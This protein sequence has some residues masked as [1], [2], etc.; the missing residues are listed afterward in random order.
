VRRHPRVRGKQQPE[1]LECPRDADTGPGRVTQTPGPAPGQA[2]KPPLRGWRLIV[3]AARVGRADAPRILAVAITVSVATV[4]IEI[5]A[6]RVTDEHSAWQATLAAIVT[7]GAGILGTVFISGFL[8][9]LTGEAGHGIRPVTL[10]RVLRSL[11]W[12]RLVL[13]DIAVAVAVVAGLIALVIPGLI[14]ANLLVIAGPVIEI[15]DCGVRAALR[16]S[17]HLVRPY[18]WRVALIATLPVV[19]L[20]ELEAAGPEP[21]GAPEIAES[22]AIRGVADGVLEACLALVLIQVTYRLIDL[23]AGHPEAGS[24]DRKARRRR[25]TTA[26]AAR[27]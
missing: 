12:R 25:A 20:S 2:R 21:A 6:E 11:P 26:G 13:A 18:F 1:H 9:R 24:L 17:A 3:S 14:L 16:R 7:E 4:A 23:D 8:C 19:V 10:R 27:S 22:L 5:I 15:E